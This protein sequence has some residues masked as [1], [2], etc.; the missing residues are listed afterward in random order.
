[1]RIQL[2]HQSI[3]EQ[4]VRLNLIERRLKQNRIFPKVV[5]LNIID[6]SAELLGLALH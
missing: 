6:R 1:V 2:T 4:L 5:F 3:T